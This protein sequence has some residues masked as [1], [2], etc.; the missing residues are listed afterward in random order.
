M[1]RY[2]VYHGKTP[3][4]GIDGYDHANALAKARSL[5]HVGRKTDIRVRLANKSGTLLW[6]LARQGEFR[7]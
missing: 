5:Y 6:A 7:G 3:V 4:G 2:L 1:K